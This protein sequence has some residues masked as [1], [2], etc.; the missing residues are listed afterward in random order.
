VTKPPP[1]DLE[2]EREA[3]IEAVL[4]EIRGEE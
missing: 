1:R 3:E 4:A 2:A